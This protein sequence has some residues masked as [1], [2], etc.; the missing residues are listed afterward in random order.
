MI[1]VPIKK[2]GWALLLLGWAVSGCVFNPRSDHMG[3]R[4]MSIE[5]KARNYYN[6]AVAYMGKGYYL[7]ARQQFSQAADMAMSQRLRDDA[8]AGLNRVDNI[9]ANRR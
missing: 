2:T 7:L 3:Y 1:C 8:V 5:R 6:D 9:I 4:E